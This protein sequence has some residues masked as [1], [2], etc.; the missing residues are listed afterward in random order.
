[1]DVVC[2]Q[3]SFRFQHPDPVTRHPN[4][5]STDGDVIAIMTEFPLRG[6]KPDGKSGKDLLGGGNSNSS[7]RDPSC[8]IGVG[9]VATIVVITCVLT[10]ALSGLLTLAVTCFCLKRAGLQPNQ[11]KNGS[12]LV[13][14]VGDDGLEIGSSNSIIFTTSYTSASKGAG[15]V[16]NTST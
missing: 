9:E 6:N 11:S 14:S 8:S 15:M 7:G 12:E 16:K 4:S 13:P 1:M 2:N 5:Q 10:A 3:R